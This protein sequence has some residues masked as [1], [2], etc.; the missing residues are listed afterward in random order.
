M[1]EYYNIGFNEGIKIIEKEIINKTFDYLKN[2]VLSNNKSDYFGIAYSIIYSLS[3]RGRARP[4][5][6]NHNKLF[7]ETDI[8]NIE[9]LCNLE[10]CGSE[11]FM[12]SCFPLKIGDSDGA[13]IRAVAWFE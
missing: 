6:I 2:G 4:Q 3:N 13:P 9:N 8:V 5:N 11:L 10:Q 12:F 1:D 7:K